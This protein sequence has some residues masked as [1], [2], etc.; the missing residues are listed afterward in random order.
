MSETKKPDEFQIEAYP[1]KNLFLFMLTRDIGLSRAILDL[2]DNSVDGARKIKGSNDYSGM[3]I[4][5]E[6]NE[7]S[8]KISDNCGGMSV[9][10]A[11]NYAFRFGRD[12]NT[13]SL[14]HSIGQ[15]GVG[16][17]RA[18]FKMGKKFKIESVTL[19][20]KF[21]VEIDVDDWRSRPDDWTFEFKSIEQEQQNPDRIG[22]T[23]VVTEL[24]ENVAQDF[25]LDHFLSSLKEELEDAQRVNMSSGLTIT[26]NS[27][28]LQHDPLLLLSS[29]TIKP[30]YRS[31]SYAEKSGRTVGCKIYAGI[32]SDRSEDNGW[33]IFCNG[34]S[35]LE[36]DQTKLTGWGEK[37]I[38]PKYH[39]QFGFFRGYV[40][41]DSDDASLLPWNT[42][43]TGVD[44]DSNIYKSARLEM[45]DAM[46]PIINFLNDL[47]NERDDKYEDKILHDAKQ[48]AKSV[49]LSSLQENKIFSYPKLSDNP[50]GVSAPKQSTISYKIDSDIANHLKQHLKLKNLS[51]LGK[52]TFDYYIEM[53]EI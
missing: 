18:L 2:A 7:N 50:N 5:L 19:D 15:F 4:R 48:L 42:T 8:F 46:R 14:A 24:Y 38:I 17:K 53:E 1:T 23:I 11:K 40:Y 12:E 47:D 30:V 45:I 41:F 37:G 10:V 13:P 9:D 32:V 36:A 29:D 6:V 28:P 3:I 16:M 35:I 26:L 34:R 51:E 44:S 33:Y 31:L 27:I 49:E 52:Y 20:S 22:T 21:V 43:K 39:P 25:S